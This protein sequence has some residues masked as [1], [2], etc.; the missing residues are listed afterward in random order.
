M[1]HCLELKQWKLI[2]MPICDLILGVNFTNCNLAWLG[3][4]LSFL[5][6]FR[7]NSNRSCNTYTILACNITQIMY[8]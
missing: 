3:F 7:L 2:S 1:V 5:T 4:S 6:L 8:H